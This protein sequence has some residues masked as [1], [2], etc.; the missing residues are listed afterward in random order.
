[1]HS[2]SGTVSQKVPLQA[3]AATYLTK[4]PC[5]L[6][7]TPPCC[8][9]LK[10]EDVKGGRAKEHNV[11]WLL[12][13]KTRVLGTLGDV[14]NSNQKGVGT[15]AWHCC[16]NLAKETQCANAS[17]DSVENKRTLFVIGQLLHIIGCCVPSP[18]RLLTIFMRLLPC[19]IIVLVEQNQRV[20]EETHLR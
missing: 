3:S 2:M 9:R 14:R 6:Q 8:M 13:Q 10:G 15:L 1:M 16:E 12:F 17:N 7:M 4:K 18:A 11:R 20:A 5:R 19:R